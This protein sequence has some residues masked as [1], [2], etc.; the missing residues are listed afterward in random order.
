MRNKKTLRFRFVFVGGLLLISLGFAS[1]V[2]M[3]P[4]QALV[5]LLAVAGSLAVLS[6]MSAGNGPRAFM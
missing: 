4:V 6:M 3:R 2:G 5:P 1:S